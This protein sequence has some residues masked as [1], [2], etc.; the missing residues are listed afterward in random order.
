MSRT[1]VAV[2]GQVTGVAAIRSALLARPR[3]NT[4]RVSGLTKAE[5]EELLDWLEANGYLGSQLAYAA[6][7]GFTVS[8]AAGARGR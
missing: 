2:G 5:A 1:Y 3:L 6:D 8:Y 7:G 4:I